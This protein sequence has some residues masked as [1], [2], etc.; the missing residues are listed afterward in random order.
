MPYF[1]TRCGAKLSDT[2]RFCPAC[3]ARAERPEPVPDP[4]PDTES[5]AGSE[6]KVPLKETGEPPKTPGENVILCADGRYRWVYELHLLKDWS[7]FFLV[8]RIFFFILSGIFVFMMLISLIQDGFGDSIWSSFKFYLYFLIGMTVLVFISYFIYAAVMGF[9]YCVVFEMDDKGILHKQ[10]PKQAKRTEIL[11]GLTVLAGLAS[12]NITTVG[13]GMSAA[14]TEMYTEF[15]KV[16]K[17]K[18]LSRKSRIKL[19]EV[20]STNEVYTAKEDFPFV[21]EYIES[22]CVNRKK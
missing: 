20:L 2:D 3:G 11:A 18:V 12:R 16:R 13:V 5:S 19:R 8:W 10:M 21:K 14:R 9:K 7:I 1:C 15:D 4:V 22:R 6:P 17:I